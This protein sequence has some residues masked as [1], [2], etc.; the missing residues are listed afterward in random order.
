MII[1]S[2]KK[3]TLVKRYKLLNSLIFFSVTFQILWFD[4]EYFL[5]DGN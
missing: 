1:N 3:I 4:L 2:L 5:V